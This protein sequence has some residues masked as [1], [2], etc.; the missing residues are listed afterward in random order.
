MHVNDDSVGWALSDRV[1]LF[2]RVPA[3]ATDAMLAGTRRVPAGQTDFA[4]TL[5]ALLGIDAA[6][7]PYMG[8]NLLGAPDDPPV[9]RPYGDWIDGRMLFFA[10]G[11][12]ANASCFN[13]AART[14]DAEAACRAANSRAAAARDV[15]HT[16]IV[17]DLQ[18]TLRSR[19]AGA[20]KE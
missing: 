10:S 18:T 1:P 17:D 6:P 12:D 16:V 14:F 4:P 15:A 19:M 13:L 8:R 9:L 11:H 5:L 3:A 2:V 7:L 20:G